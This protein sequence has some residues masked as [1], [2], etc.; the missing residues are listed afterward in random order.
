MNIE[1][2]DEDIKKMV[3]EQ[4]DKSVKNRIKE[5]QGNYTSKGY[6]EEIIRYVIW[7]KVQELVPNI[8]CYI[9]EQVQDCINDAFEI[10]KNCFNI[11]KK[12]LVEKIVDSLLNKF[13]YNQE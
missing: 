13:Q 10:E 12:E 5:M 8:E 11:T 2:K 9:R 6:L 4:V 1:I 7:D 3:E